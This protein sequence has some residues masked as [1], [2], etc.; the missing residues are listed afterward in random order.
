MNVHAL[1]SKRKA[2]PPPWADEE[3]TGSWGCGSVSSGSSCALSRLSSMR[4]P[5]TPGGTPEPA[6]RHA[7][8]SSRGGSDSL[9]SLAEH[10]EPA[11]LLT[12]APASATTSA[13]HRPQQHQGSSAV[14]REQAA[15]AVAA[16]DRQAREQAA[17]HAAA[18]A[19]AAAEVEAVEAAQRCLEARLMLVRDTAALKREE[20]AVAEFGGTAGWERVVGEVQGRLA[21]AR[22]Q[23]AADYA[24]REESAGQEQQLWAERHSA[25]VSALAAVQRVATAELQH[26]QRELGMGQPGG[27]TAACCP[28]GSGSS[29]VGVLLRAA[30]A[31]AAAPLPPTTPLPA[32]RPTSADVRARISAGSSISVATPQHSGRTIATPQHS[33]ST[34]GHSGAMQ[35]AAHGTPAEP[36]SG[37]VKG[38]EEEW[39]DCEEGPGAAAVAAAAP[40]TGASTGTVQR[41]RNGVSRRSPQ[42]A[43]S[44]GCCLIM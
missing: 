33:S 24:A 7:S 20:A 10:G 8:I 26:L 41:R 16:I 17:R 9:G 4:L 35:Q 18:H 27:L 38:C 31:A 14:L 6:R 40:A 28:N 11:P 34:V 3:M 5:P 29:D 42:D 25:A 23:A 22:Q 43:A 30:A 19:K 36:G 12:P 21:A 13:V 44:A 32:A 1:R 15:L 37:V 39:H 2:A